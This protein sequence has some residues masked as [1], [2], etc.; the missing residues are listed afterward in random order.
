MRSNKFPIINPIFPGKSYLALLGDIGNPCL[1]NYG[2]FIDYYSKLF[3]HILI[4]AG[5]HEYYS[6]KKETI[7][8]GI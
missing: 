2:Y 3:E 5:N 1:V 7:Y 8:Y 6:G 4:I